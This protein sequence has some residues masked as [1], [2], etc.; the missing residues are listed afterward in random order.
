MQIVNVPIES[1]DQRYTGQWSRMF[2]DAF[3]AR[4]DTIT[5]DPVPMTSTIRDGAF[6]DVISTIKY[7]SNQV[8]TIASLVDSGDIKRDRRVVF[9]IQDG[10][11]PIEQLAYLRDLL[12]CHYWRFV[13]IFHD[14]TYD[15]WDLT[16]RSRMYTWGEELE[17]S[18]FKIYDKI[19]VGSQ[20]HKDVL[21]EER[22]VP[23]HKINVMF[24]PIDLACMKHV[25]P[26]KEK[27]V[28]FPHRLDVEKQPDVFRSLAV[29]DRSRGGHYTFVCT[30][31]HNYSKEEYY[32]LLGRA[33][34][35]VSTALLEMFGI[36]MVEATLAGCIPLV[37]DALSYKEL[38]PD[39][40]RYADVGQLKSKL[41]C[42]TTTTGPFAS[43]DA[44]LE[45][46]RSG[47]VLQSASFFT[48]LC[49]M[50]E[51]EL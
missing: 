50:I 30:K 24:W 45:A 1:L 37:P 34:I 35:A 27:F 19:V 48:R 10:W 40:F 44:S 9:I 49:E 23:E 15:K 47:F 16:A 17:N 7:K 33:H 41:D 32:G 8:S 36:A 3:K 25:R 29:H 5:V 31:E 6:L 11:F 18:W 28:V 21:L 38:F 26:N 22:R 46:L 20:Y 14:G 12:G 51:H 43:L 13:G 2:H 39:N 4:Y 42:L